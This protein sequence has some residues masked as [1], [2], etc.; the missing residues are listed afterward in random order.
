M[1]K[2]SLQKKI[3]EH[4]LR[5]IKELNNSHIFLQKAIPIIKTE[6]SNLKS[7]SNSSKDRTYQVPTRKGKRTSSEAFRTDLEVKGILNTLVERELYENILVT[8]ISKFESFIFDIIQETILEYPKKL[9]IGVP[10]IKPYK[11]APVDLIL[12][13]NDYNKL[14]KDL[15]SERII[16][17]SYSK[18]QTYLEYFEKVTGCSVEDEEFKFYLELKATRDLIIH[19]SSKINQVYLEK[20]N[21]YKRGK[22]GEKIKIDSEYFNS[23]I[24]VMKR[25]SGI[26]RRELSPDQKK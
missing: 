19:N 8:N 12:N 23:S 2:K 20:T 25:I 14:L 7:S 11:V 21:E 17:V 3:Y 16:E 18:P 9:T 24:A 15:I 10:G 26:I 5:I 13:N 1:A 6:V 4:H 22:I